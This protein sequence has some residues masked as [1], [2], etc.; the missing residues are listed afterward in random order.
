MG[1][2]AGALGNLAGQ[3]SGDTAFA[4][5]NWKQAAVQGRIGAVSG[6]AGW[7]TGLFGALG[8][9]RAGSSVERALKFGE[10]AA[11]VTGGAVQVWANAPVPTSLGGVA[12]QR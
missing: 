2:A 12:P 6:Y 5:T 8:A 4:C 1:G 3:W 11:A 10:R 7:R 9:V